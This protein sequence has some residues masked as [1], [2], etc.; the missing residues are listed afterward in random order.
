MGNGP[1]LPSRDD[2]MDAILIVALKLKIVLVKF[3][4]LFV[5]Y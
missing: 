4:I 5:T 1:P 3:L 2:V